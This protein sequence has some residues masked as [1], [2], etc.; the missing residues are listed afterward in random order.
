[1]NNV[2]DKVVVITGAS[3]GIGEETVNLLSENGAKLVLGARRLDRL[4]KIQ[5]KVGHDSVS[6]KKTDVTKPDEVNALIETAYNDFGR[7]D[8]LINNAGLMPQSFLEKNKQD[9]W[10]QMI[11][12]NIKGV[13]YGIGAVLPYMRKQKSGHIINLASVAG[14]VVFPGSA[15]Y[16]GTKY[17]VRAITEG[18]RQE[19]AIV[20]SN[21]RTTI[22]SPGAVSTELTDHISDKDMKQDIDE[23]YKNAI[24]PDAIA[25]AINYAINEPE[26]S[27]VNEFIIRPSSQSL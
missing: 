8:V 18:L 27:S 22:L 25:R 14:H 20:G 12:V 16:C 9:E 17:A 15:V 5:Q 7:I 4:E 11:D 13:L 26:E 19:E 24:K 2:K 3:S 21:I 23:L 6:I 1:M 10:N